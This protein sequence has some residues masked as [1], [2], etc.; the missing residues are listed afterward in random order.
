MQSVIPDISVPNSRRGSTTIQIAVELHGHDPRQLSHDE[1]IIA[2]EKAANYGS[3]EFVDTLIALLPLDL[4]AV[5]CRAWD[6][7][8]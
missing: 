5:A 7:L 1:Q 2:L 6:R 4:R 8:N 3:E